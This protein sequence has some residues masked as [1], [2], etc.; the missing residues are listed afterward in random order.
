M[1]LSRSALLL[2]ACCCVCGSPPQAL[3]KSVTNMTMHTISMPFLALPQ[4]PVKNVMTSI[5]LDGLYRISLFTSLDFRESNT[6]KHGSLPTGKK[7]DEAEHVTSLHALP[8]LAFR[9]SCYTSACSRS[10]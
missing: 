4:A 8:H 9:S 7:L 1:R 5:L 10:A 3:N 2:L 6:I